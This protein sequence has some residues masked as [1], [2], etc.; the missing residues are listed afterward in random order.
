LRINVRTLFRSRAVRSAAAIFVFVTLAW[1][2]APK[3]AT[4]EQLASIRAYIRETWRTLTRSNAQ[5][6]AEVAVA[7]AKANG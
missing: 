5:L 7:Y 6:A 1:A 3:A 4:P 2:V